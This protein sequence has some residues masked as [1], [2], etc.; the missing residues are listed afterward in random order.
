[1]T[2]PSLAKEVEA[3]KPTIPK[4][5]LHR[6]SVSGTS[7]APDQ[8]T[9]WVKSTKSKSG[10]SDL[11]ALVA[12]VANPS[13]VTT[14]ISATEHA[15]NSMLS[16]I[17]ATFKQGGKESEVSNAQQNSMINPNQRS[18]MEMT[19]KSSASRGRGIKRGGKN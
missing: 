2:A 10:D 4:P 6:Q 17:R 9:E 16:V 5:S 19:R 18:G 12:P 3:A 1:M 14:T 13:L 11:S 15:V 8:I 7:G